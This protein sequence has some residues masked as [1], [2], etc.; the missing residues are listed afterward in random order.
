M[1]SSTLG[2]PRITFYVEQPSRGEFLSP[3]V[4]EWC[5]HAR[6]LT[7]L[8]S[9]WR[10]KRASLLSYQLSSRYIIFIYLQTEWKEK[11]LKEGESLFFEFPRVTLT[12]I[13]VT[14]LL[15]RDYATIVT[16]LSQLINE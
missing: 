12:E 8:C 4:V 11:K 7:K 1:L 16:R 3:N 14:Q 9:H 10:A 5:V 15:S 2:K 13:I 6:L